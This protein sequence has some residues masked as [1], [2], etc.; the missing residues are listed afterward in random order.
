MKIL[1]DNSVTIKVGIATVT[2]I[3]KKS[4]YLKDKWCSLSIEL[5]IIPASAPIGVKN[6]P[7][8]EPII[9]A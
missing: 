8:F 9:E 5:H 6:A 1:S 3:F 2:P 4:K 7:K